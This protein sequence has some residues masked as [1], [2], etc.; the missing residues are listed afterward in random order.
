IKE[1][2]RYFC[3][4]DQMDIEGMG[5]ALADRLVELNFVTHLTDLYSLG[6]RRKELAEIEFPVAFG[7]Q[8]AAQ[9]I[10]DLKAVQT[11][12]AVEFL[13][14]LKLPFVSEKSFALVSEAFPSV[15][16]L[17]VASVDQLSRQGSEP[18]FARL[19]NEALNPSDA[20]VLKHELLNLHKAGVLNAK[21]L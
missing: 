9:I 21:G 11:K 10:T 1:R 16:A 18:V 7:E 19:L 17:S 5:P 6:E 8:R 12:R 14:A 20:E 15:G 4:R 3:G 13:R 2:L